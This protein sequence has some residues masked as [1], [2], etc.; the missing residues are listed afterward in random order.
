M[1][2]VSGAN[3]QL[4]RAVVDQLLDRVPAERVAASV[5]DPDAAADLTARGVRV[6]LGDFSRPDT[7]TDAFEGAQRVLVVSAGVL[8]EQGLAHHRAAIDAAVTAGA[9]RVVYTGHM[10]AGVSSAFP[11]MPLHAAT[12]DA[13]AASGAAFT[14]LRNGFYTSSAVMLLGDAVRTGQLRLPADGPIAWT[15]HIDLAAAAAQALTGDDL[16]EDTAPL[17]GPAAL[18]MGEVA[19]IAAELTG[20]PIRRV[21]IDD[22]EYRADLVRRGV[23]AVAA[24]NLVGLFAAARQGDFSPA[25]PAL[26]ELLGRAPSSV[27]DVLAA[28]LA[29][30]H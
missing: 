30:S 10:G 12:R 15:A 13:L 19:G 24:D 17:T 14:F 28:T 3:G 26:G 21:V 9:Q 20:Q 6:R 25:D 2:V 29:P 4:G 27:R 11:P 1:I 16:H 22:D 5:R 7:L 18:D 8:G 23:P